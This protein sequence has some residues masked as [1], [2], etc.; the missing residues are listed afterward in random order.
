MGIL[1]K[2]FGKKEEVEPPA[3]AR[4]PAPTPDVVRPAPAAAELGEMDSRQL[5]RQLG[6][7]RADERAAA[8]RELGA[9][10]ER[11][12]ARP[13]LN[14]YLNYG[15]PEILVALAELGADFAPA[16]LSEASDLGIVGERRAR[17][18]NALGATGSEEAAIALRKE[19][20]H[21]DLLVRVRARA[22]LAR[23][24]DLFGVDE[25]S[26]YLELPDEAGRRLALDALRELAEDIP[27][28]NKAI[29]AH[30]ERYLG[31]TGA[32]PE[33]IAISAPRLDD[34]ETSLVKAA[35]ERIRAE[36]HELT[37]VVGS[38]AIRLAATRQLEVRQLLSEFDVR[39]ATPQ[40][41]P[42]EQ[43]DALL[44]ARDAAAGD[45]ESRVVL[46]GQ[47]P[48]PDES[49]PLPHFLTR[50]GGRSYGA[51]LMVLDPHEARMVMEWWH[52][53]VDRAE[54]PTDVEVMLPISDAAHSA[55]SEE[56]QGILASLPRARRED[57]LRAYLGHL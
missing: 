48:A 7:R 37:V 43:I 56:E 40:M 51:K 50:A 31:A 35:A 12:A 25:L 2:L 16:A 38:D 53:I 34:P 10:R 6:S 46:V 54:V 44:A 20:G 36:P 4:R 26:H 14:A 27:A 39:F 11:T 8:A 5:V 23:L 45:P 13:L 21:E 29:E 22:A 32:I 49:P 15:D 24:G 42:E 18:M 57:F 3:P 1:D 19:L 41:A 55:I 52:Y 30:V 28:A 17:L 47:L 33:A 9:R